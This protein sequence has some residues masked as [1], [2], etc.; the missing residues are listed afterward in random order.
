MFKKNVADNVD[1]FKGT[2]T[3]WPKQNLQNSTSL[4]SMMW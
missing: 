2:M 3:K 1:N 4:I